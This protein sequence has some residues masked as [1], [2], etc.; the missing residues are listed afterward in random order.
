MLKCALALVHACIPACY[1]G[2]QKK[3][4]GACVLPEREEEKGGGGRQFLPAGSYL[5]SGIIMPAKR[6]CNL[7][8]TQ[9]KRK[10]RKATSTLSHNFSPYLKHFYSVPTLITE[11]ILFDYSS[12]SIPPNKSTKGLSWSIENSPF[13]VKGVL[14]LMFFPFRK[15]L[16]FVR[17]VHSALIQMN[18]PRITKW[19]RLPG[20][21]HIGVLSCLCMCRKRWV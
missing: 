9:K 21:M 16:V 3:H 6:T 5:T 8:T 7:A 12:S 10:I 1:Q 19:G 14:R 2:L 4:N 17:G 11:T 13:R 15:T 18:L 20:E